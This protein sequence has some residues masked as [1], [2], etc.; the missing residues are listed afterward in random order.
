MILS[1]N[2]ENIEARNFKAKILSKV[3][4]TTIR[5]DVHC[6]WKPGMKAQLY[7][8]NP[9]NGGKQFAEVVIKNVVPIEINPDNNSITIYFDSTKK[10]GSFYCGR[11]LDAVAVRD[12]FESWEDMKKFFPVKTVK[13]ILF[14]DIDTLKEIS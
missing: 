14:F 4:T 12:G 3:K 5:D 11:L 1:F 9:R 2:K 10:Y 6:R 8:I 7:A 13:R